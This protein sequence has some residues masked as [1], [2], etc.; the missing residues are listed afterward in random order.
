MLTSI[1]RHPSWYIWSLSIVLLTFY[2]FPVPLFDGLFMSTPSTR[3]YSIVTGFFAQ[4]DPNADGAAIGPL[5]ARFGLLDDSPDRWEKFKS[6]ID[7]LQKSAPAGTQ[8]KVFFFAR[9]GQ[10]FH[11]VGEAKYG[12][13]E[14]DRY[15]SKLDGDGEIV[16]GPD[17]ELT[18]TG[19]E[20]A[21]A[22]REAWKTER[23]YGVPLPQKHYGSPLSRALHTFD[24]TFVKAD[25]IDGSLLRT[26]ILENLREENG[27]HTCDKRSTKSVIAGKF[28]PPVYAFEDGFT[29]EDELWKPDERET[30]AHVAQ[31]AASVFDRIFLQ[32]SETYLCLTAHSGII[33]GFLA[34][35]GRSQ[36]PLP[37]GGILPLVVKAVEPTDGALF[38]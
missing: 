36:Y 31:R 34:S 21:V 5:P 28:P 4:D 20:Q 7:E 23:A 12:T 16:W 1:R 29:E 37:T 13:P 26:T 15:W 18:Q 8:Y 3:E 30:K 33:N 9:H 32:D 19:I 38:N 17:A 2:I 6:R 11:N 22:A 25:F 14:W 10:G 24:E 27:E 35:M